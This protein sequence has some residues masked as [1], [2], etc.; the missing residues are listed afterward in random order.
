LR[1]GRI[2]LPPFLVLTCLVWLAPCCGR[3]SP[4]CASYQDTRRE[5]YF[6]DPVD[7]D[8][9][10]LHQGVDRRGL[11]HYYLNTVAGRGAGGC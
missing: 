1:A 3:C 8:A 9:G 7:V 5:R 2:A 6:L 10:Q 4:R 11:P